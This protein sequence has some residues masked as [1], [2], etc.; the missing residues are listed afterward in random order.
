MITYEE[1]VM[2][3]IERVTMSRNFKSPKDLDKKNLWVHLKRKYRD[4]D[5]IAD[6]NGMIWDVWRK[7]TGYVLYCLD[8]KEVIEVPKPKN[9]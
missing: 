7:G 5:E 1:G 3:L 6:E 8:T 9:L 4:G 2:N